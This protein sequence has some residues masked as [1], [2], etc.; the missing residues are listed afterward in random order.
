MRPI[1]LLV[2]LVALAGSAAAAGD[3]PRGTDQFQ[4]GT[5]RTEVNGSLAARGVAILS[6]GA[7]HL[8]AAGDSPL[9]E[10]EQYDFTPS[11]VG[12]GL[13]WRVTVAYRVPY[14]RADFD[15]LRGALVKDLGEPAG[16]DEIPAGD[17]EAVHKMTWVDVMTS[18][19]LAARWPERPDPRADRMLVVWTDRRLQKVVEA[20]RRPKPKR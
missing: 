18:V 1:I 13:L 4:L 8:T 11:A 20:Q 3:L 17:P 16:N 2:M 12:E 7:T 15:S 14:S 10:F 19:Q 9:V 5:S 6:G